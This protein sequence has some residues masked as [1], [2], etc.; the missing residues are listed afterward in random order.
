MY[1]HTPYIYNI[2]SSVKLLFCCL[3]GLLSVTAAGQTSAPFVAK[4]PGVE[5]YQML[6]DGGMTRQY[7]DLLDKHRGWYMVMPNGISDIFTMNYVDGYSLGLQSTIGRMQTDRSRWE[8]YENVR[9]AFSRETL[10]AKGALRY[11]WPVEYES[12]IEINGGQFLEDFDPDPVMPLSQSLLAAG[13]CGWNHNKYYERT[14]A[15]ISFSTPLIFDLKMTANI[16]WE[17]RRAKE[18]AR[19][20]NL[21][22]A[23]PQSNVPRVGIQSSGYNLLS[24]MLNTK[25]LSDSLVLYDGPIDAELVKASLRFDYNPMRSLLVMDDLTLKET[26]I[27]PTV[28]LLL[29]MG[30]GK[31]RNADNFRFV[32]VDMQVRQTL[33]LPRENDQLRYMSSIGFILSNGNLGLADM[34]HFDANRFW[35]QK[36]PTVSRFALLDNYELST[37]KRWLE[38]HVEWNSRR[39]A[40]NRLVTPKDAWREFVQMHAVLVPRH[41]LHWESQYGWE[42]LNFLRVGVSVG[43]DDFTYRGTAVSMTLDLNAAR[44]R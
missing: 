36:S 14:S 29:D 41:R 31:N 9:W 39:M 7:T 25:T 28:S 34:H 24:S 6:M 11:V 37:D 22:G 4:K 18:N 30:I 15:G 19:S 8:L 3:L 44:Q 2:G 10:V 1:R 42:L 21:F 23:H 40:L 35:W 12:F 13:I 26:L 27:Y 43:F 32:S 38:G 20:R 17:R 16:G 5:W 33:D